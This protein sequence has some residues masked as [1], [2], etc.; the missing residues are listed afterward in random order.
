MPGKVK[1]EKI[2]YRP[3]PY[4]D[5]H[6]DTELFL[7]SL[8]RNKNLR[9]YTLGECS[10]QGQFPLQQ[11]CCTASFILLHLLN[12]T[13]SDGVLLVMTAVTILSYLAVVGFSLHQL[14]TVTLLS[15][16]L[17]GM[18][19]II[20]SLTRTISDDTIYAMVTVGLL[21]NF[22]IQNYTPLPADY[23]ST[24]V[25]L[26][27]AIFS[28][29]CLASRLD[30]V[31]SV[32]LT[33][34]V[35]ILFYGILPIIRGRF[36]DRAPPL[37]VLLILSTLCL[38]GLVSAVFILPLCAVVVICLVLVPLVFVRL[39]RHKDNIFGPWDEAALKDIGCG[40]N[41]YAE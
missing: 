15:G 35:A 30:N 34:I 16:F 36:R 33:M 4:P 24:C 14:K 23:M 27:A 28:A 7:S 20:E 11:L 26:N 9:L 10:Y 6:T 5:N 37:T 8:R 41:I 25:S 32:L 31:N 21:V 18:A 38:A 2:L 12:P 29:V 1:F 19:P 22:A 17:F 13:V 3:Q 39:Q 40:R